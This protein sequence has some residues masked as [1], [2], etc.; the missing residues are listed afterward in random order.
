M[1]LFKNTRD[2]AIIFSSFVVSILCLLAVLQIQKKITTVNVIGNPIVEKQTGLIGRIKTQVNDLNTLVDQ[3]ILNDQKFSMPIEY[4]GLREEI[5]ELINNQNKIESYMHG[6][7]ISASSSTHFDKI[8]RN[9]TSLP[10]VKRSIEKH[11]IKEKIF[12]KRKFSDFNNSLNYYDQML[13]FQHN[14]IL[15]R[16]H[17]QKTLKLCLSILCGLSFLFSI[18][19]FVIKISDANTARENEKFNVLFVDDD[20]EVLEV[21]VSSNDSLSSCRF[22]EASDGLKALGVLKKERVDLIVTDLSMPNMGG[23]ELIKN[24]HSKD[25][26]VIVMTGQTILSDDVRDQLKGQ[27]VYDKL[28]LLYRMDEIIGKQLNLNLSIGSEKKAS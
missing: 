4:T 24:L 3:S 15:H 25:I 26:P 18:I 10:Q 6:W 27:H 5:K 19:F 20:S 12:L 2:L 7:N 9:A 17:F 14:D 28:D 23:V 8:P 22:L 11:E 1:T 13:L 21:L 16:T